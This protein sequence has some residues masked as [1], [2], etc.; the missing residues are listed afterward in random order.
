MVEMR[1]K[2]QAYLLAYTREAE[3]DAYPKGLAQSLHLAYSRDGEYFT[4]LHENYGIL[5]A[6]G[7]ISGEDTI[8]P[9]GMKHPW[10]FPLAGEGYGILAVRVEEDGSRDAAMRGRVLFWTTKDF[11]VFEE[12]APLALSSDAFVEEV[13]CR[14]DEGDR[15]YHILWKDE[16]GDVWVSVSA[17]LCA[18]EV[19]KEKSSESC[20]HWVA[21][22]EPKG[23][24]GAC[25]G[26]CLAVPVCFA[27]RVQSSWSRIFQTKLLV[28]ESVCVSGREE[29][30]KLGAVAV[31]SDGSTERKRVDWDVSGVDFSKPGSY[32]VLGKVRQPSYPFP[33]TKGYGDPVLLSWEGNWYFI[34]TND[35]QGD[36]RLYM[37]KAPDISGLFADGVKEHV[38]L[39]VDEERGF[40]Q[41]FWAPEFHVIGSSLY[42]LFAVGGKQWGPQCWLMRHRDGFD[43][44]DPKGWE[45]P[46][47]VVRKDG[48]ALCADGI[49]LDMTY[50]KAN[51]ASYMVWSYRRGIGT[52]KDTGSMLMIAAVDEAEPWKLASDPVLLSRPLLGW[53]NVNGTINNEGPH[54][55]VANNTVYLTYSG[56][57]ACGYTYAVGLLTADAD[58]D[59]LEVSNWS[60]RSTPV[61]SYYSVEGEY[62]PGHNSFF[63]DEEGML[64][65]AYH[66]ETAIDSRLRCDGMRRVHFDAAGEPVFDMSAE[67]DVTFALAGVRVRVTLR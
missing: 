11:A 22:R 63:R 56:G 14:Y 13:Q 41:T 31:Y 52:D 10:I 54:A 44:I 67:R 38:V 28:P 12:Q 18:A 29:L 60:K 19:L 64:W 66:G 46:V 39:D 1:E 23:I 47:R 7:E 59:L 37:R 21:A 53:E 3:P 16:G 61:L 5:F 43:L 58:A 2:G 6:S 51:H 40:V 49:T 20:D 15:R 45:T 48:S 35:N 4:P 9:K 65:I 62:G 57:D 34:A 30:E 55:F 25:M 33:L 50:V 42:I 32:E 26:C 27:D 8:V 17:D 24:L 36:I